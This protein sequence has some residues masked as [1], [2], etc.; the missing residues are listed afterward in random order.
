MAFS[1]QLA[2]AD[3]IALLPGSGL[4]KGGMMLVVGGLVYVLPTML[5]WKRQS[6]RRWRITAINLLLGWT[7]IGWIVAMVLT[8]AYE[9]PPV[10]A[11]PDREHIPGSSRGQ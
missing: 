6:S 8:Y 4:P 1:S 10:G 9:P 7:V 5:A 2:V 11:D 3:S